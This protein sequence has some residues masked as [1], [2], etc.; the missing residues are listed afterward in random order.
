MSEKETVSK[1]QQEKDG[2][3]RRDVLLGMGAAASMVYA[4]SA[5][6]NGVIVS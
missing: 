1:E 5:S 3:S 2:I 4:G 6:N